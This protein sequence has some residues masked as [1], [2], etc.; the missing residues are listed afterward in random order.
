MQTLLALAEAGRRKALKAERV[1]K[2]QTMSD[3]WTA[4]KKKQINLK[5]SESYRTQTHTKLSI[6]RKPHFLSLSLLR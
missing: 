5:W 6:S 4:I 1:L 3:S 2:G